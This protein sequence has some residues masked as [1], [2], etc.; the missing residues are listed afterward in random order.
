MARRRVGD[1]VHIEAT[2]LFAP[3]IACVVLKLSPDDGR[4]TK[5]KAVIKDERLAKVGFILEGEDWVV[6]EW[7]IHYN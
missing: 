3:H 5:M 2:G 4:V 6:F 7:D 1:I